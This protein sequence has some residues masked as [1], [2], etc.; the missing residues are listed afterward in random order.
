MAAASPRPYNRSEQ[1]QPFY[2]QAS[3]TLLSMTPADAEET[4]PGASAVKEWEAL[5][6][7]CESRYQ[8]LFTWRT[9]VWTT[10]GQIAR[11]MLPRRFYY[12]SG[13][14]NQFIQGLRQD[15]AIVDR[16]ATLAGEVCAAGL[17]AGI[18]DPDRPWVR[19]GPAIPDFELDKA[20]EMWFDDLTER[21]RY[22]LANCGFYD[23][24]AQHFED[25]VF[26]GNAPVIDYEDAE[27]VISCRNPCAGEYLL[28]NGFDNGTEIFYEEI[29]QTVTQT[30]EMFGVE[31]C[32]SD[33]LKLWKQKGGALQQE[34]VIRHAIEPNFAIERP[35]GTPVGRIPGGFT[36]RE[37]WWVGGRKNEKPLSMAGFHECPFAVSRWNLQGNE[38]YARG[39][40]ENMLGD[41]IQLQL[42]TR[43]KAESIEKV[44]RP[45]MGADV[46]LQNL[47]SSTNP[48]KI[49]YFN[50]GANGEKKFFPLFEIKPDIPAITADIAMIQERIQRTAYNNIFQM[51][52]N[53]RDQTKGNVTA[54]E[55][56]ALRAE[57]LMQMGPVIGRIYS[58]LGQRTKRHLSIMARQ[59]LIPPKPPSLRGVPMKIEFVSMLTAAQKATSTAAIE[60]SIQFAGSVSAV[61]PEARFNVNPDEA[62]REFN[63]GIGAPS[64]ILR[65]PQ[66]AKKML[67]MAQK[68]AQQQQISAAAV[69]GA[70]IL[71]NAKVT[72]DTALGQLVSGQTGTGQTQQ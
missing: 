45:P 67:A 21:Y 4:K 47:P 36:W 7:H 65:S 69:Q 62:I 13:V 42:E 19:L 16:T 39:I 31:N 34:N 32:P 8:S 35:D 41:T 56:D 72:P 33:I 63:Q 17:M 28:G 59:G 50:T 64:R 52:E 71:G 24:Q 60:R 37:V 46:T 9:S 15:M 25:L 22:V 54:T 68:A 55:I 26:F 6:D 66:E 5:F 53:L 10:W 11:Y 2:T 30:V 3:P 40:G 49:T 38:A 44:N 51:M 1:R 23:S 48:G 70:G 58:A 14:S 43:Q 27:K 12:F 20:G 29:R 18:T 57:G 61:Y